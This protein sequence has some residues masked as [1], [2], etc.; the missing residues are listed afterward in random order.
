MSLQH[1]KSNKVNGCIVKERIIPFLVLC[2][3][4][5]MHFRRTL[6]RL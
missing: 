3:G 1:F 6:S 5:E 4:S 2:Y